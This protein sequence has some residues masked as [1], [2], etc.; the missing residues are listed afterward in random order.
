MSP[1]VIRFV[2]VNLPVKNFMIKLTVNHSMNSVVSVNRVYKSSGYQ[3]MSAH[4][5]H[6]V[7]TVPDLWHF[8]EEV[9]S[10]AGL[11]TGVEGCA[12][13]QENPGGCSELET[14]FG[15]LRLLNDR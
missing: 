4:A 8:H 14:P 5:S 13:T 9:S 7:T 12:A 1:I 11:Y 15:S 3:L 6:T 2:T 10:F